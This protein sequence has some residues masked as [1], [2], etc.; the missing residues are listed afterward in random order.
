ML[1]INILLYTQYYI[2]IDQTKDFYIAIKYFF[3]Q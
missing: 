3:F 1:L 2:Y